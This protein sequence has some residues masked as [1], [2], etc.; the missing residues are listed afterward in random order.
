MSS[1][2]S[3]VSPPGVL[4]ALAP[5]A[6]LM[7]SMNRLFSPLT[8]LFSSPELPLASA[9][10]DTSPMNQPHFPPLSLPSLPNDCPRGNASGDLPDTAP[11]RR[12]SALPSPWKNAP[13]NEL[14]SRVRR[15]PV[16]GD[17][18]CADG[19]IVQAIE[20]SDFLDSLSLSQSLLRARASSKDAFR[21][22]EVGA[23]V[24]AWTEDDWTDKMPGYFRDEEWTERCRDQAAAS[25]SSPDHEKA[26]RTPARE[27]AF[28]RR[29]LSL[30]SYA[31][32]GAYLHAAAGVLQQGI[33]L[34]SVDRRLSPVVHRLDDFGTQQY[35]SSI[36]LL[37]T[38]GP[39]KPGS[40]GDG[41]YETVCLLP[42]DDSPVHTV[43]EMNHPLL[44]DIRQW[45]KVHA[46]ART[47]EHERVHELSYYPA[48]SVR[49][50]VQFDGPPP[51]PAASVRDTPAAGGGAAA[52][53]RRKP[54][55]PAR[56]RDP[57]AERDGSVTRSTSALQPAV[58]SSRA[59][60]PASRTASSGVR[61]VDPSERAT[62][63]LVAAAPRVA[64]STRSATLAEAA[65]RNLLQWVRQHSQRGR[66]ASRI[67]LSA[68]PMWTVRCRTVLQG[69]AGAL[70]ASP[71]DERKVITWLC[72]LWMLPQEVF[73]VPGRTRGGKAGRKLRHHRIHH[74]LNDAALLARLAARAEGVAGPGPPP[75]GVESPADPTGALRDWTDS[76][77]SCSENDG[78]T[79][80]N[81]APAPEGGAACALPA[82]RAAALRAEHFFRQ[83]HLRRALRALACTTG[84]A[85]LDLAAERAVLS[86]LHPRGPSDLP[87]CPSDAPELVVDPSWMAS[88]MLRSDTGAA[89]GPSGY[90]S[91]FIKVL[92]TD[93]AC[94]AAMA[95]LIGHIV[96][97]KLP[98][99]VR[100]LLNT[101]VLVSLEKGDGG[102]RPVA[103]GDMFYR[104]ASRFA[105]S[106]VLEPAKRALRPYQFG[107]G[108]E[109][110]CTQVVQS[111]QHLLS[112]PPAPPPLG[113]RPRHQFALTEY[114]EPGRAPPPAR[115][116]PA[117]VDRTPR[118]LACLSIDVANAFNS[119]DRAALLK[120]V[121]RQDEL[122]LCWRMVAFGY[123]RPTLLLMRCGD[124]VP[125][126]EAIIESSNGVRQGDPLAGLLFA[127]AMHEVY[128]EVGKVCHA[129]CF[130]FSDDGHGVGWLEE[131]WRAWQMLPELLSPLGLRVNA[132][133]C[134][135]TCFHTGG[136]RH[137][138]DISALDA[139][140]AAG[141]VINTDA[142]RVLGCVVGASDAVTARELRT[143]P[144]F[145][146]DQLVA[147]E[148]LPSLSAHSA[149]LALS[150]LDGA[151]LTNR[152]RA[153]S[154]AA[155]EAHAA[156]YD[157]CV[158]R[159]ARALVGVPEADGDLY[160][161][162]LQ[163]PLKLC[164]FAY[165]S[166]GR[167]APAAYLAGAECTLRSSPVFSAVWNGA[168]WLEATWPITAAIDDS[169]RRVAAVEAG[170]IARCAPEE[171]A[172]VPPSALPSRAA[173]F[174]A[175]FKAQ[176]PSPIQAAVIHRIHTLS[177][178]ARMTALERE[179]GERAQREIARLQA[180]KEPE[181]DRWLRVL[182]TDAGLRLTDTQWRTAAQLR[183]GMPRAP[184]GDA[185]RPCLHTAA[186][187]AD[188]W[189]A[190]VCTSRSSTDINGRHHGVVRLLKNA[191]DLL[192][193]P[194]R[195]EPTN[196]CDDASLRPDIQFDLPEVT[197]LSDVTIRHPCA[198]KWR[199]KV[200][201]RGV[202]AAV[203]DTS[204]LEKTDHY[205]PLTE[206]LAA[207]FLPFVLY[208]YGGWHKSAFSVV[209]KLAA[210][211][212]PAVA[213]VSLTAW[214]KELIDRIAIQ[215]Q[216]VTANIIINDARQARVAEIERRSRGAA[217]RKS[218]A[219][220]WS[221]SPVR[222]SRHPLP[223][224]GL[225][226]PGPRAVSLS[227]PLLALSPVARSEEGGTLPPTSPSL[228]SPSPVP[229]SPGG[230]FVPGTPGMDEAPEL[231]G[232][233]S[234]AAAGS[235]VEG[236]AAVSGPLVLGTP[237]M[238]DVHRE[239]CVRAVN[240]EE[241]GVFV[242]GTPDM[243][244]VHME[245][246]GGAVPESCVSR[247]RTSVRVDVLGER[248]ALSGVGVGAA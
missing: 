112:L 60:A 200:A 48:I 29:V 120:A 225:E 57:P 73:T 4:Q 186:A 159:A 166:A 216:R 76:L 215:V 20:Q 209:D 58:S 142:L 125:P 96:N 206:A 229:R 25:V 157:G 230:A 201:V 217:P 109:D 9:P 123:G 174:V 30:P 18:T 49:S 38:V 234:Y 239:M 143:R 82:A 24:A 80:H 182:P 236:P 55:L 246:C 195:T 2:D 163:L 81:A 180:L 162:L 175:H 194:V 204:A 243:D 203:G 210:A 193:I 3:A 52:R 59:P 43:F 61:A 198:A 36:I 83:G 67:H 213:L 88:E 145:R 178:I 173:S 101:C 65:Q 31:V 130:A 37:L 197:L 115:P 231:V 63:E 118:P 102:R 224:L 227:A 39:L 79:V 161:E 68:V 86:A 151:V 132:A 171:L 158:L 247:A 54:V 90:G 85:D 72:V 235:C 137:S 153:M 22:H 140:R 94:V 53:P 1:A 77:P 104:M 238:G 131:C 185:A 240:A 19:A 172:R 196:L 135:L 113:P 222:A 27:L 191:A 98:A 205:A 170:L 84:K 105:L 119:L 107:V 14:R 116:A 220:G 144:C 70:Q 95:V 11:D 13:R 17:G 117:P 34:L 56:L 248:A 50:G 199:S 156:E 87:P 136:L 233:R 149:H 165:V 41:H 138:A 121:Y 207:E 28:F 150:H 64:P 26:E 211:S 122:A 190:L 33:L 110:G 15:L 99:S 226:D 139:F 160:D 40:R 167:I 221:A 23:A 176:P 184:H 154:P 74:L 228:R 127:L 69:L 202:E 141:V 8:S 214:K 106:L 208:S 212:D 219:H 45:A 5:V 245:A 93:T 126:D 47:L 177:T 181:S 187:A 97:D 134:E 78:S 100:S 91:N 223:S 169:L 89:P 108:V 103:M 232:V 183:L 237:D 114:T 75:A 242:P 51:P 32:G 10:P 241:S 152:L 12:G 164:G 7:T 66:L 71:M 6:H 46:D 148:R 155:T 244:D 192:Q 42:P 111:L 133:K 218:R 16:V 147:F 124:E 62:P 92:A 146:A 168:D 35:A 188:G 44:S 21:E 129:G 189:H 179:G 128:A